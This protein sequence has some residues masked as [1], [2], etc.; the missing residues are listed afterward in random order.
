MD[1]M[2]GGGCQDPW[3]RRAI[4]PNRPGVR[5]WQV[6]VDEM[7][8]TPP[9]SAA[10][11]DG[12][13]RM[14]SLADALPDTG[15]GLSGTGKP[16]VLQLNAVAL[17]PRLFEELDVGQSAQRGLDGKRFAMLNAR[18]KVGEQQSRG[19]H[20]SGTGCQRRK[21]AGNLIGVQE[22]QALHFPRQKLAGKSGLAGTVAAANHVDGG[23]RYWHSV[24]V[25]NADFQIGTGRTGVRRSRI[26]VP[27]DSSPRSPSSSRAGA[28]RSGG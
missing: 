28:G 14:S 11:I 12:R 20:S 3:S 19:S 21:T 23:F 2:G 27:S 9:K 24:L 16:E 8:Q 17:G 25:W 6:I 10:D 5:E 13:H 4:V 26:R 7:K 15:D 1:S 18:T 22:A